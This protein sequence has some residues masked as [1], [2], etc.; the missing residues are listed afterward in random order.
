LAGLPTNL[1]KYNT[2]LLG[3]RNVPLIRA[4]A[5]EGL[6]I[7]KSFRGMGKVVNGTATSMILE[8]AFIGVFANRC[9]V[10]I[11]TILPHPFTNK[12]VDK[13]GY[14]HLIGGA[15]HDPFWLDRVEKRLERD[16]PFQLAKFKA[17]CKRITLHES[18]MTNSA[19]SNDN[20]IRKSNDIRA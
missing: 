11:Q 6:R 15:K 9:G 12:D 7:A 16:F 18:S 13:A 1:R 3:G 4:W 10:E 8:Q 19:L 2:G 17:G 20:G 14:A 5:S